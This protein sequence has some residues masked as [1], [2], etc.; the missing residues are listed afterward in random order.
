VW[1]RQSPVQDWSNTSTGSIETESKFQ[2]WYACRRKRKNPEFLQL[3]SYFI[4]DEFQSNYT[5]S[6]NGVVLAFV[7][8]M[9]QLY[10]AIMDIKEPNELA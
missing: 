5:I 7:G 3:S 8:L 6:F 1:Y 10:K 4:L 9:N 2:D